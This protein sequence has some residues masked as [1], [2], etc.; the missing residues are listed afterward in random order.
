M[1]HVPHRVSGT[2]DSNN[3]TLAA[4]GDGYSEDG[5]MVKWRIFISW[6]HSLKPNSLLLLIINDS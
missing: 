6:Q 3:T 4:K 1:S 5:Q 2:G